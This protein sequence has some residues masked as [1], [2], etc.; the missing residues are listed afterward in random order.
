MNLPFFAAKRRRLI[1]QPAADLS[2][3]GVCEYRCMTHGA[4][5]IARQFVGIN[6]GKPAWAKEALDVLRAT[7]SRYNGTITY[8]ELADEIQQRTGLYTKAQAR[9]WIG[10]V[11]GIVVKQCHEQ[12]LPPLTS[13]VVHKHDGQV[14][15]GYDEVLRVAGL[16]PIHDQLEREEHAAAARLAC[17]QRF[18]SS[19]P[20]D[21]TPTLT[22]QMQSLASRRRG[23]NPQPAAR[24]CPRCHIQLPLAGGT[25]PNCD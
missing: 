25:C 9:N 2:L 18:C 13:L 3:V 5:A 20:A 24:V 1:R 22:P 11:L 6:Q 10:G 12:G 21:A 14:G 4:E 17:H 8:S 23:R 7:A 15:V 16:S 19:V